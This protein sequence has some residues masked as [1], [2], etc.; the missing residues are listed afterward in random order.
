MTDNIFNRNFEKIKYPLYG[1]IILLLIGIS[2]LFI[3][4]I[5][6][7]ADN[8]DYFRIISQ[9]DLYHL[10]K[11]NDD[12][13]LGYFNKEYGIYKYNNENEKTL[14]STQSFFIKVAVNIDK[15]I[16][17]DDIFDIRIL[18][19]IYLIIYCIGI[20]LLIRVFTD[21]IKTKIHKL[22]ITIVFVII[23]AD[24]GY[25]AYFNS[26]FGE[27][28][29]TSCFIFSVGILLYIYKFCKYKIFYILNF[30]IAS[31]LFFGSKQQLAPIGIF[32]AVILLRMIKVKK[33]NLFKG[34]LV[35]L[36]ILFLSSSVYFYKSISGDFDYINRYH[37]MTRGILLHEDDS[38]EILKKFSIY[39]QYSLLENEIFF[40]KIPMI[41]PDDE[42]LKENFYSRYSVLS[43]FF[44]YIK[45]PNKVI[46]MLDLASKNAYSIRPKVMGNY[47]KIEGKKFGA[48]SYF[49][50]CWSSFK[51]YILPK[52]LFF[53]LLYLGIYLFQGIKNYIK[54]IKT[55][56]IDA[57]L[58]EEGYFYIFLVGIS[59][60]V[61]S[62]VGAGDADLG[63]H[64]F[65]YNLSFDLIF[66]YIIKYF[67]VIREE[68]FGR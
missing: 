53:T 43:I 9:N 58:F 34:L 13:F 54:A 60:V 24:T 1:T 5:I 35:S 55:N 6:G 40:E 11:D 52:G 26:F 20:Y 33:D 50:A 65:M 12:I 18:A 62:I 23:F 10:P 56:D 8:G 39:S 64:L 27:G 2:T 46:K 63:K 57:M 14:I 21:D 68:N 37:A 4:P 3:K 44:Y 49:F 16:T 36:I 17:N 19:A 31:F 51:E 66:I 22:I 59:Q 32:I 29:N 47:E 28:V 15:V 41:K 38:E 42:K 25:V 67:I 7:V 30:S 61:I 45:N 48:K